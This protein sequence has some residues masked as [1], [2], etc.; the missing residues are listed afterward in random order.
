[1]FD[2][3][4]RCDEFLALSEKKLKRSVMVDVIKCLGQ[5]LC[6]CWADLLFIV[7]NNFHIT[8]R[9]L[10]FTIEEEHWSRGVCCIYW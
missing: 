1:M 7:E 9:S 5:R 10:K 4:I 2:K 3:Y 8:K 6:T